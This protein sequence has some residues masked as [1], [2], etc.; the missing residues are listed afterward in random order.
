M[1]TLLTRNEFEDRLEYS[2]IA[3][4]DGKVETKITEVTNSTG[5]YRALIVTKFDA[6]GKKIPAA[7]S[8]NLDGLYEDYFNN[9]R[10][11]SD[12]LAFIY[13]TLD[14]DP[15]ATVDIPQLI[16]DYRTARDRLFV[17]VRNKK[18]GAPTKASKDFED[19]SVYA[20]VLVKD[21]ADGL[22]STV[23]TDEL[24]NIWEKDGDEV[25]AEA[26]ENSKKIMPGTWESLSETL[27]LPQDDEDPSI[28]IVTTKNKM[29]AA[30]LFYDGTLQEIAEA[31][32]G[33]FFVIPSS[34]HEFLTLPAQG[35]SPA[36]LK[37]MCSDINSTMV[38]P[39]EK[40]SDN[41]YRYSEKEKT[42]QLA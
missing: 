11:L 10:P 42:F 24:L 14:S 25:I 4:R 34:I 16:S 28:F 32:G 29:T 40:L 30:S 22:M 33:D 41:I 13:K 9:G 37:L 3:S 36:V 7:P 17:A 18:A 19:L 26:L 31:Y 20:R 39:D 8:F 38:A 15:L 27:G 1:P 12:I 21:D 2:V 35:Y 23:V 5:A 6:S